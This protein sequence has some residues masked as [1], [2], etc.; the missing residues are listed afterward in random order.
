MTPDQ[1]ELVA[2]AFYAAEYPSGWENAPEPLR[3]HFRNL[4]RMAISLLGQQMA[5]CRSSPTLAPMV[6]SQLDRREM[7]IPEIH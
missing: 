2:Q 3:A 1:V 4:A 7:A 5:Q 6:R